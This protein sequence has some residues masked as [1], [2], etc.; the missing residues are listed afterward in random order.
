MIQ[1]KISLP[2]SSFPK[3]GEEITWF[4]GFR[5]IHGKLLGYDISERPV[6]INQFDAPDSTSTFYSIRPKDPNN[7]IAPNWERL[8]NGAIILE[9]E[10]EL[11]I[12]FEKK[13][14][15][16]I[17]PGPSYLELISEVYMRGYEIYL[18]GGTV[19]DF[20]QGEKSNDIDLVTTM[21]LKSALP[22]IESMFNKQY[23]Y[24]PQNGFIRIGGKPSSGDPFI[25]LKNFTFCNSGDRNAIFGSEIDLDVKVRDFACNAVY[26]DPINQNLIDPSGFGILDAKNKNLTLVKDVNIHNPHYKNA[27]IVI[28]AVKFSVRGYTIVEQSLSEIKS[29]FCPLFPTMTNVDRL[30]YVK[31][32]I[33]SKYPRD[34][35]QQQYQ[36]FVKKMI[37][38][39]LEKEY[40]AFIKPLEK[41]LNL[42]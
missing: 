32:Q 35:H 18:V 23:S 39:G 22:L 33:L 14:N 16:R 27:Q 19:R 34:Q 42:N 4:S 21:P 13:L 38:L 5:K 40:E 1:T 17:P 36:L 20:L 26:Y 10:D 6:I 2:F 24:S 41:L 7:R 8:P 3:P 29:I 9:A 28:R 30:R 31:A 11:K 15:E 12:L 37:E 25:D